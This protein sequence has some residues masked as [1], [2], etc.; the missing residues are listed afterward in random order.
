[1]RSATPSAAPCT[2]SSACSTEPEMRV[3]NVAPTLRVSVVTLTAAQVRALHTTPVTLVLGAGA[4]RIVV[5]ESVALVANVLTQPFQCGGADH[6][7]LFYA[8]DLT[9]ALTP[10]FVDF[11]ALNASS[12]VYASGAIQN[13][14]VLQ[15]VAVNQAVLLKSANDYNAGGITAST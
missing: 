7:D 11:F 5:V 10:E 14:S 6:L 9:D 12:F 2:W 4:G 1:M 3:Q 13:F 15:S 8:A